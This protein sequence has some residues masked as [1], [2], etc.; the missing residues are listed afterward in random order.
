M[1]SKNLLEMHRYTMS[2][3][4]FLKYLSLHCRSKNVGKGESAQDAFEK[5]LQTCSTARDV[6]VVDNQHYK[7]Q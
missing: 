3:K 6:G 5:H 4:R 2:L 7:N 1:T